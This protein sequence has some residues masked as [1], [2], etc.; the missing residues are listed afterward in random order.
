M[1][2]D[3]GVALSDVLDQGNNRALCACFQ[4]AMDEYLVDKGIRSEEEKSAYFASFR[5]DFEDEIRRAGQSHDT[6][7]ITSEHFHRRMTSEQSL[8]E[9]RDFLVRNF[10]SIEIVCYFREQS[11]VRKSLYSTGVKGGDTCKI[12]D[13]QNGD[14]TGSHYYNY[15]KMLDKWS[16]CFGKS[17]IKSRLFGKKLFPDGDIRKDFLAV[18]GLEDLS[19]LLDFSGTYENESLTRFQAFLA[20]NIN[21]VFPR[22][23]RKGNYSWIRDRAVYVVSHFRV[24][25][26][27]GRIKDPRQKSFY[28]AFNQ[29]NEK[30]F[31]EYF[32]IK[33]NLFSVP[34]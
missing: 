29:E 1:L 7:I 8:A 22:Y 2:S 28:M 19:D 10:S 33:K 21:K 16:A 32:G 11:E 13:F 14:I 5:S 15:R 12:Q 31:H 18:C 34:R 4:P 9:L 17:S 23:D 20:R 30:F 26:L 6:M 25:R 3:N 24:F 27:G